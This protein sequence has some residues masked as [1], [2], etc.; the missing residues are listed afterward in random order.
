MCSRLWW[1]IQSCCPS[2]EIED[3]RQ[4]GT[5]ANNETETES[6]GCC[7]CFKKKPKLV[8]ISNVM[9]PEDEEGP[10]LTDPRADPRI[11]RGTAMEE[12]GDAAEAYHSAEE[13]EE[14]IKTHEKEPPREKKN[15]KKKNGSVRFKD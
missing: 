10:V 11:L 7:G 2:Q 8:E 1:W 5:L 14:E 4:N 9:M 13:Q 6:T 3:A 15:G 12:Y